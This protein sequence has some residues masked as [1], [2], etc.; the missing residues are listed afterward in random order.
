MLM[1]IL[2]SLISSDLIDYQKGYWIKSLSFV[3][4]NKLEEAKVVLNFIIDK[5][6]YNKEKAKELLS[7]LDN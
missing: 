3:K 5:A 7:K 4:Q 1:K 6:Y 2:D